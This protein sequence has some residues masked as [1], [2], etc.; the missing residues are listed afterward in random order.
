MLALLVAP[1]GQEP[2]P[3]AIAADLRDQLAHVIGEV[4]LDRAEGLDHVGDRRVER[5]VAGLP[6]D[7]VPDRPAAL[8]L[9][10]VEV[11]AKQTVDGG[12]QLGIFGDRSRRGALV[13]HR[14]PRGGSCRLEVEV[15]LLK[16]NAIV[17]D[18][19]SNHKRHCGGALRLVPTFAW[20]H[21][22]HH[23]PALFPIFFEDS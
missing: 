10:L 9:G 5:T 22:E 17:A 12:Q 15:W 16:E 11:L 14:K 7:V 8:L 6:G 20:K 2:G 3:A 13:L 4:Q 19:S 21:T 18:G 1:I 23:N